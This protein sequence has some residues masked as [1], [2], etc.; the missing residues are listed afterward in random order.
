MGRSR[1]NGREISG[2]DHAIQAVT[3]IATTRVGTRVMRRDYGSNL[4]DLIG[5]P[6]NYDIALEAVMAIAEPVNKYEPRVRISRVRPVKVS[7]EG[8]FGLECDLV[9]FPNGHKG[10]YSRSETF[11]GKFI[12]LAVG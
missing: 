12:T 7:R 8:V 5:K 6:Q 3:D 10:D 9:Y 1:K 4:L 2:Y 11:D